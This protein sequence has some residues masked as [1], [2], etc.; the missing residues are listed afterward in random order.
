MASNKSGL[1]A[2]FQGGEGATRFFKRYEVACSLNKWESDKDM[3]LH[4]LPLFGDSVF[5]YASSLEEGVRSKYTDLKKAIIQQ[6]DAAILKTSVAE[7]FTERTL[8]QGETLTDL[9]MSLKVL[10]D[11]AYGEL[12]V[13]TTER[14]VRDQFIKSLPTEI[15]RH[16][17]LQPKLETTDSLLQEALKAEEVEQ[18]TRK[19]KVAA[20]SSPDPM[21]EAIKLLTEKVEMLE[22]GQAAVV[23]R[24]QQG[25]QRHS[26]EDQPTGRQYQFSGTCYRCK[27]KGHMARNCTQKESTCTH[28]KNPGHQ[29]ENCAIRGRKIADF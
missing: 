13:G 20:V 8:R 11:K 16:V 12:P 21:V 19:S 28:C 22:Q 14:L 6:Y 15:R 1:P 24:V 9:M 10:A 17:L 29:A 25:W 26:P 5:D 7:Q 2:P 3:A 27:G 23:A 18:S 4:V